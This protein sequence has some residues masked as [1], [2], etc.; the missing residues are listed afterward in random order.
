MQTHQVKCHCEE[1]VTTNEAISKSLSRIATLPTFA[2][3]DNVKR[4][5]TFALNT[6][7]SEKY[8]ITISPIEL[9]L[10]IIYINYSVKH[11]FR[12]KN[13]KHYYFD[14]TNKLRLLIKKCS[15]LA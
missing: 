10:S 14:L 12:M 8:W 15:L 2:R 7:S 5:N 3:N 1:V 13:F 4:F 11:C 6:I 9:S